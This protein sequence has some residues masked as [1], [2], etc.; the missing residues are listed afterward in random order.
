ME[1]ICK[2]FLTMALTYI[3]NGKIVLPDEVV[4]GKVL[5]F[6]SESGKICGIADELPAGADIIDAAGN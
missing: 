6:D 4:C 5:A 3:I 2:E 1:I